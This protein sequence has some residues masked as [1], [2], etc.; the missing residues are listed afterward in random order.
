MPCHAIPEQLDD[1][2]LSLLLLLLLTAVGYLVRAT[3]PPLLIIPNLFSRSSRQR[4]QNDDHKLNTNLSVK[5]MAAAPAAAVFDLSK[6]ILILFSGCF[7]FSSSELQEE[8]QSSQQA[9]VTFIIFSPFS[10]TRRATK[11]RRF[12][13]A[14]DQ[15]A[16]SSLV[17]QLVG[18]GK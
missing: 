11:K 9:A 14:R 15:C 7:S 3:V 1:V 5:H 4:T 12:E 10:T 17:L 13:Q 2:A 18:I 6:N 16:R 8:Q